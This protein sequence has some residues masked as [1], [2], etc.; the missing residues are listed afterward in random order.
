MKFKDVKRYIQATDLSQIHLNI[1][2]VLTS[3]FFNRPRRT[4]DDYRQDVISYLANER[5]PISANQNL[6]WELAR[7]YIRLTCP[8]C[9]EQMEATGGGSGNDIAYSSNYKCACGATAQIEI[10]IGR[11][12]EFTPPP[13]GKG[14]GRE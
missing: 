9:S 1:T 5:L 11:G 6:I 14:E 13:S 2:D 7:Q 8:Y 3:D 12:L 10:A 4:G